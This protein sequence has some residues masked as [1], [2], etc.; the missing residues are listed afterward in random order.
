MPTKQFFTRSNV[1]FCGNNSSNYTQ[2]DIGGGVISTSYST[3]QGRSSYGTTGSGQYYWGRRDWQIRCSRT[4]TCTLKSSP[5]VDGGQP[6]HQD[7]YMPFGLVACVPTWACAAVPT[8]RIGAVKPFRMVHALTACLTPT[9]GRRG[10]FGLTSASTTT[11]TSST[12]PVRLRRHHDPTGQSI[13]TSTKATGNIGECAQAS[14]AP[15]QAQTL[16]NTR[17]W[18]LNSCYTVVAQ[19]D[20]PDTYWYST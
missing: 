8:T 13:G 20:D 17:V 6:R 14:T 4:T 16:G 7:A 12:T 11:A 1:A 3:V 2:I 10:W 19:T 9:D 15:Y 5:C 18:H